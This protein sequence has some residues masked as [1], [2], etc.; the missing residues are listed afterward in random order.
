[1]LRDKLSLVNN[2]ISLI[3]KY[4]INNNNIVNRGFTLAIN[5]YKYKY[6]T[7]YLIVF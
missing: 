2:L 4:I 7:N 6:F 5:S 1:M 3:K